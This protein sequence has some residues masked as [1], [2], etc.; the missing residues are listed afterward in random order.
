MT[1]TGSQR[2]LPAF[3]RKQRALAF[4]LAGVVLVCLLVGI[5]LGTGGGE[6]TSLIDLGEPPLVGGGRV[7]GLRETLKRFDTAIAPAKL[8]YK[9]EGD[10]LTA[11][12]IVEIDG[13][14]EQ[15]L[16]IDDVEIMALDGERFWPAFLDVRLF[17]VRLSTNN[18]S[19]PEDLRQLTG[20]A[21]LAYVFDSAGRS[22][23]V[24]TFEV[25]VADLVRSEIS[26]EFVSLPFGTDGAPNLLALASS[27]IKSLSLVIE[28]RGLSER[29][30]EAWALQDGTTPDQF[31]EQ[32]VILIDAMRP[33]FRSGLMAQ[34]LDALRVTLKNDGDVTLVITAS[35]SVPYPMASLLAVLNSGGLP[36]LDRLEPLNLTIEAR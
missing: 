5:W 17:G 9:Q 11:V 28:D 4:A 12:N 3:S 10:R 15:R 26:G 36:R 1:E 23:S 29:L 13:N 30:L 32:A 27:R 20:D 18:P 21:M 2:R 24:P 6:R 19:I 25:A 22:L 33:E 31:R 16:A 7:E 34:V 14:R 35:P 8:F